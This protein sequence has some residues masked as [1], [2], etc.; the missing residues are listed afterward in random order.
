VALCKTLHPK[1]RTL[2]AENG[3]Q[4]SHSSIEHYG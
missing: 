3:G 4:D 2:V 1:Q